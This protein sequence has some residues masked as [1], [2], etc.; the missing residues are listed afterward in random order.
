MWVGA[1]YGSALNRIK[2]GKVTWFGAEQGLTPGA[3]T[4]L[5]EDGEA[6]L[7][8]GSRNGLQTLRGD[9]VQRYGRRDGLSHEKVNALCLARDGA[10]WIG[11]AGGLTRAQSGRLEDYS[12]RNPAL[13]TSVLCLYEDPGGTLWL[14]TDGDGLLR[15]QDG[16]VASFSY[17]RGLLSGSIYSVLED[18]SGNLWLGSS[19]GIFRVAKPELVAVASGQRPGVT[20]IGYGKSDGILSSGQYREVTQPAAC[21]SLD[22][23]L[24]FRSTQGVVTVDPARIQVNERPPPVV[25]EQVIADRQTVWERLGSD[26]MVALEIPKGRGQLEIRYT[27]LSLRASE[28]NHFRYRLLGVDPDW[29]EAGTRRSAYYTKVPPGQYRFEATASNNDGRW[30]QAGTAVVLRVLPYFW[31]TR[32]FA[33]ASFAVGVGAVVS[34]A[35]WAARLRMKRELRRLEQQHAIE[36]ER[37]RIARDMHDEL[38]AKLARISFQGATARRVL[39]DPQ[40]AA[41]Q[42]EKMAETARELVASLDEIVWAVDPAND[43]LEN[44]A[45]YIC[46]YAGQFFDESAITCEFAIPEALPAIKLPSDVRH[47]LFL[48]C[49]EALTNVMRHARAT[50]VKITMSLAPDRVEVQIAD[51]G[52]GLDA[53]AADDPHRRLRSGNGLNN[54]RERL[55]TVGGR[56]EFAS[57]ARGTT[58]RMTVPLGLAACHP[59]I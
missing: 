34:L 33:L 26:P 7:W 12:K 46:R 4:A 36:R 45:G 59:F 56:A 53:P 21:R 28:R 22:G 35:A 2:E 57:N 51:N 42:V 54:I 18:H 8:I 58:V 20:S 13:K 31:Q 40:K 27:A 25:I 24:W 16:Q 52:V 55:T 32:A 44:I 29:V 11:T 5:L 41:P 3:H 49:K 10:V 43:S 39:G 23:R 38:G 37:A 48:A 14:G 47:H 6:R 1:D 30:N 19:R 50:H 9:V 17:S 15:M